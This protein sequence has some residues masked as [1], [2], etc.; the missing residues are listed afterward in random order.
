MLT[1]LLQK[2]REKDIKEHGKSFK[3]MN[4]PLLGGG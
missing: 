3:V 4:M 2:V 1:V